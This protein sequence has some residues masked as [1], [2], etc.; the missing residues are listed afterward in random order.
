MSSNVVLVDPVVMVTAPPSVLKK[1]STA[2]K[3]IK[4]SNEKYN[5]KYI[6]WTAA[7]NGNTH[8]I[9]ENRVDASVLVSQNLLDKCG[10]EELIHNTIAAINGNTH[11]IKENRVDESVLV[12]QNSNISNSSIN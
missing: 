11:N 9:K 3:V 6:T 4:T 5:P 12:S 10:G 1:V 2:R 7:V 8:K